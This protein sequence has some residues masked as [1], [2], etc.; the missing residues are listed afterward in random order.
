M[1]STIR[2][3]LVISLFVL[4]ASGM[5]TRLVYLNLIDGDFLQDQGDA[6][7]IR[8]ERI[9]AHRGMIKDRLG[10]PLAVS[11]PVI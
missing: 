10:K 3:S 8:I 4:L 5:G 1:T 11:S 9:N 2:I 7:T 6:R